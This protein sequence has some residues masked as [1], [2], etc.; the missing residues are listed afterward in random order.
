MAT[1]V[2]VHFPPLSSLRRAS[3]S[4]CH[5]GLVSCVV[6]SVY[7]SMARPRSNEYLVVQAC[8]TQAGIE[9][10]RGIPLKA[11][12]VVEGGAAVLLV[13]LALVDLSKLVSGGT[14]PVA[15]RIAG[16]ELLAKKLGPDVVVQFAAAALLGP[17]L[18]S[19]AAHV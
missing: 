7:S 3:A 16:D 10:R 15:L 14:D 6:I 2:T 19:D 9:L 1:N 18:E 17:V 11:A 4:C 13:G 12:F 5:F 8:G